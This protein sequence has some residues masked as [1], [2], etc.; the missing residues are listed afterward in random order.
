MITLTFTTGWLKYIAGW[1]IV[2]LIRFI[3]FRPPN[4][5]PMLAAAMPF[6]KQFGV[7]GSFLFGFLGII[8]FDFLTASVGLWTLITAVAYGA[9]GIAAH[10]FFRNRNASIANFAA[11]G[12]LGTV[13]YDAATGLTIGPIFYGQPFM[14]AL[15]GQI[16][17]TIMHVLGTLVFAVVLS[18]LLHKWIVQNEVLEIPVLWNRMWTAAR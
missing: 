2:L 11:F 6:S 1:L 13:A 14:E 4:F 16:P 5:E 7:V 12:F 9:V 18:P 17:F 10:Y 3:P 15:I 8:V